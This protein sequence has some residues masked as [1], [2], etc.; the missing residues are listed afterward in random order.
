MEGRYAHWVDNL[1]LLS[2]LLAID[3]S[4]K[5]NIAGVGRGG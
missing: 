3:S 5:E 2:A 4:L 1:Q